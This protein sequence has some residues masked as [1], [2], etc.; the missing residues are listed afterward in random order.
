MESVL[1]ETDWNDEWMR[2]QRSRRRADLPSWWDER[3]KHFR[4]RETAPYAREFI[5]LM[6]LEPGA[7]V[8]DM[9]CGG[10]SLAIPLARA[11]HP[12]IA[13]D[14]SPAMLNAVREG[15]AHYGL[16]GLLQARELAWADDWEAAGVM[17]KSV[18]AAIASR[19]FLLR[20]PTA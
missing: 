3:A 12:V 15:I 5:R 19:S 2:L 6:E 11:G 17:P 16:H 4:P 14:F 20:P 13:A 18:D 9:G 7:S 10:G 1:L 8:L